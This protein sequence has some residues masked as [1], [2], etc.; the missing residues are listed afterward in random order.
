MSNLEEFSSNNQLTGI[1]N[2]SLVHLPKLTTIDLSG[3]WLQGLAPDFINNSRVNSCIGS[4][5]FCSYIPRESC[6]SWV[7]ILLSIA[8]SMGY[9]LVLAQTWIENDPCDPFQIWKGISYNYYGNITSVD[10][11]NLRL[12]GTISPSFSKL[13][14]LK[15]LIF[16]HNP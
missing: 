4:N 1:I 12:S 8:E 14:S 15:R 11:R 16:S 9:P 6:D 7:I 5:N 13:K 2:L 3:N 10:F